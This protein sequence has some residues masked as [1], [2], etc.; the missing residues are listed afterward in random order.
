MSR[1]IEFVVT[2]AAVDLIQ[3][4]IALRLGLEVPTTGE[5]ASEARQ[6]LRLI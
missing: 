6:K 3:F 5:P 1:A 2:V 4:V